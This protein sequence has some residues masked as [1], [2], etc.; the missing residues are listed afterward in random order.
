MHRMDEEMA[1]GLHSRNAAVCLSFLTRASKLL[2][3]KTIRTRPGRYL[4][5][6]HDH[7]PKSFDM[8]L[9]GI[10]PD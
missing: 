7:D 5:R 3:A 8:V 9:H 4:M 2:D 6:S 10:Y 1:K